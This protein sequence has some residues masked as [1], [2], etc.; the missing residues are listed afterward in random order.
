MC[1][2]FDTWCIILYVIANESGL[3]YLLGWVNFIVVLFAASS[4][5]LPN[6]CIYPPLRRSPCD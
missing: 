4:K 1:E 6:V 3:N 2:S 5:I